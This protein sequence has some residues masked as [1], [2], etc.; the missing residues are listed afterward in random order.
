[1]N[2]D[3]LIKEM[4]IEEK[5]SL[6]SGLDFWHTK[7]VD[8][9]GIE[10]IMMSDGPHGLRKVPD[11]LTDSIKAVC[12]PTASALACSFDRVL[13]ERLGKTIANECAA[14]DVSVILGPG[15]NI[16]RTPLCGRNFEYFSEDPYLA[17][18][19]ATSYIK[20]VQSMGVGTSLKHFACNNQEHR[21]MSV[22]AEVDERTF[23]E[24]YLA[25]FENAVKNAK[26]WTVMCSY[27]RINGEYSSQNKKLLADILRDEWGYEGLVVSDWGAVDDRVKGVAAGL[28]LEMPASMGKNDKLIVKAVEDGKLSI[29]EVD[30]CVRR[31]LE[32]IQKSDEANQNASWDLEKDHLLA[33]E[34]AAECTVLLKNDGGLLPLDKEKKIAFIGA[35]A[36]APRFQGG[37]SSH[38]NSFKITSAL[39][40][41]GEYADVSFAEGYVTDRDEV[42]SAL[43]AEAVDVAE[44]ADVAVLFAGLPDSFESEGYDR[45]HLSLPNCQLKLIDELLKVNKNI[46]LVLHN[47]APVEM[48]FADK[49]PAIIESYLGGEAIGKAQADVLF[50]KVNPSGKLAE[51]FPEKL[52]D[53][54]AFLN[55]PGEGDTVRYRE[56]IFVGYRYYDKKQIMP[57]FPFGHGLSYTTFEYSDMSVSHDE[58][59]EDQTLTVKVKITNTGERAGKET[60]QLYV[61]NPANSAVMRPEKELRGFE[62]TYLE[63]GE[64]KVLVFKLSKRAFAYYSTDISDWYA[65]Y[66]KY[67]ILIGASSRDIRVSKCVYVSPKQEIK[68]AF[69]LN[70]LCSDVLSFDFGKKLLTEYLAGGKD[71]DESQL[72]MLGE[73]PLRAMVSFIPNENITRQTLSELVRKLNAELFD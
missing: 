47:G 68:T 40:A 72:N 44:K 14:E 9:L 73:M 11:G 5:A 54:P 12:F 16:K 33:G 3:V 39:E 60:V 19:L 21:R 34:I 8:R 2:I 38:I 1:M 63:P 17:G 24:M 57:M 6:L 22:S 31:V 51:T 42:D 62:K 7:S 20:G 15:A 25:A 59:S 46:V 56:G 53:T 70:S 50:G 30:K 52:S 45:T 23:R 29:D 66:G 64:S 13:M 67:G 27:N 43:L 35:F 28:D 32:L 26:P 55:Y 71:F 10:S 48:P 65:E 49:I 41:A 37:G 36:K 4:T 18:E 58:L 61:K 69:T